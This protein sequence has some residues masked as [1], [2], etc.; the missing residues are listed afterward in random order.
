[1][2]SA[3]AGITCCL[4]R[5]TALQACLPEDPESA[6][7]VIYSCHSKRYITAGRPLILINGVG[8]TKSDW[9]PCLLR[10]LA[11]GTTVLAV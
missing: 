9:S 10:L 1:M 5:S 7:E 4:V 3:D 8:A 2:S 6:V 11:A